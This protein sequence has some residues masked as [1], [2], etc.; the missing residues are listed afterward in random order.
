M[1]RQFHVSDLAEKEENSQ[2]SGEE[3][4][5]EKPFFNFFDKEK[6]EIGNYDSHED[7]SNMSS[8]IYV[9]SPYLSVPIDNMYHYLLEPA[10]GRFPL[11]NLIV[12]KKNYPKNAQTDK[13]PSIFPFTFVLNS[14]NNMIKNPQKGEAINFQSRKQYKSVRK[15]AEKP[16]K[17]SSYPNTQLK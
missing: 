2:S 11:Q 15:E 10:K 5:Q 1:N 13:A 17:L 3:S 12:Y 4:R 8:N 9:D 7:N 6:D 16:K 14:V